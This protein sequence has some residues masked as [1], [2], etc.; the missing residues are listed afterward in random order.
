VRS[1]EA[2]GLGDDRLAEAIGPEAG[3]ASATDASAAVLSDSVSGALWTGVSRVSGL[4]ETIAVG[5][6]LGATYL[7][8]TFQAVN[9]LPNI[10]YYQLLAGSLFASLL[11]PLLVRHV[12]S[13]DR[14]QAQRLVKG[15]LG[16]L[17]VIALLV[18]ALLLAAS[19]L[20]M[21]LL[22]LGVSNPE[23]KAA[24]S[25]VGRVLFVMFVPQI[26]LYLIAGTG[27]A[28]MNAHGRFS[29]AAAAPALENAGLITM[30]FAV[31]ILFGTGAPITDVPAG[32]LLLLGLGATGAVALHAS[33]QWL[34][35]RSSGVL[36]LP[37]AG[38]RDPEVRQVVRRIMPMLAYTGL[39]ATQILA[40][41]VVANKISG[42]LVAFQLGLNFFYLPAAI[43]TWPI[44]RALL[45]HLSRL[46]YDGNTKLF[47]EEISRG[48]ALAS[49]VAVPIAVAY[50]VLCVPLARAITF[51]LLGTPTGVTMVALSL[52]TVAVGVVG[53]TWFILGTY[54]FYA[55]H[56]VRAPLRSM[57][58]R[59]AVAIGLMG[60][61]WSARGPR[62]LALLGV[63]LSVGSVVG[64]LHLWIR[65]G[66]R[67]PGRGLSPLRS[68]ARGL[69]ASLLM[70]VPAS[71]VAVI[72]GRVLPRT[73]LNEVLAM[74][75]ATVVGLATYL[76]VQAIVHAPELAWLKTG[77]TRSRE[78][79][80]G[81]G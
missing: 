60:L 78:V 50:V 24:Q 58:V 49:F 43:V 34:G 19:P 30:L 70:V 80:K 44:A 37:G 41:F 57:A 75:A 51:G 63:A 9:S 28:V 15:F 66:R 48:V 55:R 42:G 69:V 29:L 64:A 52:A 74:A 62:V 81:S 72:I 10:V 36:L 77:M 45:P 39:A 12:D 68:L 61:A 21:R 5:A 17:L 32:E 31:G 11:V 59:V 67:L 1:I 4:I 40:V 27:A 3:S 18:S 71:L 47:R 26:T 22:T 56:D 38:W 25:H 23:T 65:L 7:G 35:S 54:A 13:G 20:I 2:A 8:N 14:V 46:H 76:G 53:E 79:R 33:C 73:Q 6:I 16:I